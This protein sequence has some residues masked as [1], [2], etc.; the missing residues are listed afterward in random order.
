MPALERE[1]IELVAFGRVGQE[2][3]AK[4]VGIAPATFRMRLARARRRLRA[5]A[6][7]DDDVEVL[8]R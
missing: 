5:V 7:A 8:A 3:A 2:D 6:D 4:A 1:A